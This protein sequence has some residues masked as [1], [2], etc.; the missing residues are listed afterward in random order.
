MSWYFQDLGKHLSVSLAE[1]E[2]AGYVVKIDAYLALGYPSHAVGRLGRG[3]YVFQLK[4][5]FLHPNRRPHVDLGT[6]NLHAILYHSCIHTASDRERD[7]IKGFV[8]SKSGDIKLK[9]ICT[10]T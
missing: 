9:G 7:Y 4:H 3:C 2:F 5:H 1:S 10:C 6:I 8:G